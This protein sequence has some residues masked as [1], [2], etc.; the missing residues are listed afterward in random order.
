[1]FN[2]LQALRVWGNQWQHSIVRFHCDNL[3]MVQ[4]VKTCKTKDP[5]LAACI[6]N[7]WMITA[8][9]DIE[10]QIEHVKGVNNTIADLLS[11]LFL[12]K[13]VDEHFLRGL[14]DNYQ[15]FKIPILHFYIYLHI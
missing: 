9:F 1:M 12:D 4:G 3:A 8:T 11:R 6:H 2:I 13:A 14:R 15:W 10:I 5:F 7:I